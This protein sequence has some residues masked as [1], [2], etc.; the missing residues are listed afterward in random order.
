MCKSFCL[1]ISL[2]IIFKI[3]DILSAEFFQITGYY[4][5]L[6]ASSA[7]CCAGKCL[8]SR[9]SYFLCNIYKLKSES[10]VRFIRPVSVHSFII[11]H[12]WKIIIGFLACHLFKYFFSHFF[13]FT[14]YIFLSYKRHFY[15][16]LG[17]FRLSVSSQILIS[18]TFRQLIIFIHAG[19]HQYLLKQL[20][21]LRK[22]IKISFIYPAGYY[23]ISCSFRSCF[24]KHRCVYIKKTFICK[25][26]S[27]CF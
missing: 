8:E 11:V 13:H 23:K 10:C 24:G 18:E 16:Q 15:I 20:R 17:K 14:K 2:Y 21:R 19:Y 1:I 26:I 5:R 22:C 4:Y 9:I 7:F 25:V 6:N 3:S 12:S 27:Y